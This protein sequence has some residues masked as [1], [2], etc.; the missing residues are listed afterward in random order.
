MSG[1]SIMTVYGIRREVSIQARCVGA[2]ERR[3]AV[4]FRLLCEGCGWCQVG[5]GSSGI[6]G[7]PRSASCRTVRALRPCL[8]AVET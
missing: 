3:S 7:V 5:A 6:Q 2:G 8:M 1:L 4:G